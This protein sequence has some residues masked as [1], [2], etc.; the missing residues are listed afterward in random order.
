MQQTLENT[1]MEIVDKKLDEF[2]LQRGQDQIQQIDNMYKKVT[3][4]VSGMERII[5]Q[6]VETQ[7]VSEDLK[8]LEKE[9]SNYKLSK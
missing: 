9:K 3:S 5:K 2:E 7:K 6:N 1:D 4:L 8:K